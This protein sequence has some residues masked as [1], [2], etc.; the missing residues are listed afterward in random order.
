MKRTHTSSFHKPGRILAA[1]A[2]AAIACAM[3]SGIAHA[4]LEELKNKIQEFTLPNG[5][6]FIVL[7]RH[8]APVV[9]F[10]T[11]ADVGSA[12]ETK[13]IT[14]LAHMFEHMAFKGSPRIG[15][16]DY[17][18]EKV[19]LDK[20]EQAFQA[21]S[22]ERR[23]G[24]QADAAKLK[25]LDQ[26]F[27]AAQEEAGRFV[28]PNEFGEAI[29][30]AGGRGLNASTGADLTQYFFS[31]P[32]NA[33][34]LWFYLESER[35]YEPVLREFYKERSVVMEERRMRTE[36]NPIGKAIEEFLAAA[37]KAHPYGEPV[38]GHMSDLQSYSSD[39]ARAFAA[40]YY[41]PSNLTSVVVGDI[42]LARVKELASQYFDRIPA[43]PR[44]EPLRT[45]EPPQEVEKRLTL[46]LRAQRLTL[47]GYHKPNIEIMHPDNAV[48]D[49]ISSLLSEG[50]SS[51]LF[52]ALVRDKQVAV[53]AGGF[54]GM[55]GTK[56]PGLFLFY[57]MTAPG[58][59]NQDVEKALQDE[60]SKLIN[61]KVAAEDL[62]G[63]KKRARANMLR[64]L[65][66][67]S[68][69]AMDLGQ[70]QGMTGDWRNIFKRLENLEAVTAEDIQRVAKS[71]FMDSNKTVALI[72][73]LETVA[74]TTENQ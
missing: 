47:I 13:G 68:G 62:E 27:K 32:S 8:E 35:Y 60:I 49:A 34:E 22:Q 16:R 64:G 71:T 61:E 39:D 40:K 50:R 17:A 72:E 56:Y 7:E 46:R 30:R 25:D 10:Y 41:V 37:Y 3:T 55:P 29:E 52:R 21:W 26:K 18:A 15:T 59:S 31:L 69:M 51:R 9:S 57:G 28:V 6:K 19:A 1:L 20:V 23:K 43:R 73:P 14:G 42:T 53:Q 5:L 44:P 54:P 66:S 48:F 74:K 11:H 4:Q 33:A 70:T 36:S 12:Q 67:N 65:E 45:V 2:A 63:V 58:K 24:T 38:I